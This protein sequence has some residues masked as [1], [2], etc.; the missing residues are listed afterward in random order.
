MTAPFVMRSPIEF[1]MPVMC[2]TG[3]PNMVS[4]GPWRL[5]HRPTVYDQG[6][7]ISSPSTAETDQ[8]MVRM[9]SATACMQASGSRLIPSASASHSAHRHR[10]FV[11]SGGLARR[12]RGGFM[13]DTLRRGY[14]IF[15]A[16]DGG[17]DGALDGDTDDSGRDYPAARGLPGFARIDVVL[18]EQGPQ[19][20]DL[21]LQLTGRIGSFARLRARAR[22]RGLVCRRALVPALCIVP[23]IRLVS[24]FPACL[25]LLLR[26][27]PLGTHPLFFVAQGA[28][29]RHALGVQGA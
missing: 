3:G 27:R 21:G 15:G 20:R 26:P 22:L 16:P 5:S 13:P 4:P 1:Q 2:S 12:L 25:Q 17:L 11:S 7:A 24:G 29:L 18:G 19:A 28:P 6:G 14:D 23:A 8:P 10:P 9:S